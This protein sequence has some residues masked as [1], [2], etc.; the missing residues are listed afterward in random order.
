VKVFVNEG[1]SH[2]EFQFSTL[3]FGCE[4]LG[5]PDQPLRFFII[6]TLTK[7]KSFLKDI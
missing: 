4:K 7:G 5:I 1:D 2:H 3:C 6:G